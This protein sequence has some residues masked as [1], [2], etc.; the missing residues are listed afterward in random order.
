MY[1]GEELSKQFILE[2]IKLNVAIGTRN[3]LEKCIAKY[4][5]Y[6]KNLKGLKEKC[7][8]FKSYMQKILKYES[9][10]DNKNNILDCKG[11]EIGWNRH[12]L[13]SL[14]GIRTCPYCNRQYITNYLEENKDETTAD[15]D[16]FY[17]QENYPFLALS[18]YNFIPS[19]QICNSRFKGKI[20]N[21]NKHIYPYDEEF[22]NCAKFKIESENLSYIW[23]NSEEFDIHIEANNNC[24]YKNKINKSI[25][26]F[27][28]NEVYK[29][30]KD[31]CR[32][33]INRTIIYNE[34]MVENL[35]SQYPDMFN[36]IDEVKSFVFGN[37]NEK[38]NHQ[39]RPLTK[40]TKDICEQ[41]G[42]KI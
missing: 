27:K 4:N 28:L 26:T 31:Y 33:L 22:G 38:E 25:K 10:R 37:Y 21:P 40:L 6:I 16:H 41:F 24:S 17:T 29:T 42:I 5:D 36:N 12:K 15:L 2:L 32:E 34:E 14:I 9:F 1:D 11:N 8:E 30:H 7:D 13:I 3:D 23:N 35:L 39:Y 20:F 18:L 19:C